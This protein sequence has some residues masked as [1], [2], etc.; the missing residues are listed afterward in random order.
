MSDLV[1][2]VI[3]DPVEGDLLTTFQDPTDPVTGAPVV[4]AGPLV[5]CKVP[6]GTVQALSVTET[7]GHYEASIDTT[8]YGGGSYTFRWKFS[9]VY[10]GAIEYK[11]KVLRSK[12]L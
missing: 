7:S 6:D 9:G 11:V 10:V 2:F 3:Y 1:T 12:V 4:G 5:T 8:T